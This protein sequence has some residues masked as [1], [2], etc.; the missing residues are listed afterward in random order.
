M[1]DL[2]DHF[3][4]SNLIEGYN[5]AEADECLKQAWLYLR[6]H[7][8]LTHAVICRTQAFAVYHQRDLKPEWRGKYRSIPVW[9]GGREGLEPIKIQNAMQLWLAQIWIESPQDAHVIF[10]KIH[11]FVD[12][13]GR[14][15][16]LLMWWHEEQLG[17]TPTLIRHS[18]RFDYYDW[19]K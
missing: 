12:G 9:I 18:E 7:K 4:Q 13:N 1:I 3:H 11:P 19:F 15:G 14:T 10:E 5:S 17:M 6:K 16:R 2:T 8:Q